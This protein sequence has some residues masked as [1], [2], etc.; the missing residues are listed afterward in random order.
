MS[1]FKDAVEMVKV[2][3]IGGLKLESNVIGNKNSSI[4]I[5]E[6]MDMFNEYLKAKSQEE[7]TNLGKALGVG[8]ALGGGYGAAMGGLLPG[9]F[10]GKLSGKGALIGGLVGAPLGLLLGALGRHG[11]KKEIEFTRGILKDPKA[12][13][14]ALLRMMANQSWWATPVQARAI[15][16]MDPFGVQRIN[17]EYKKKQLKK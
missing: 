17:D 2:A 14:Q 3:L 15:S 12:K 7:P 13:K 1:N 4:P 8:A 5:S 9:A 11:D 10:G 16:D 6:R